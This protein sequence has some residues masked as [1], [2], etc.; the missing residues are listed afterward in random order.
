MI[1]TSDYLW[2]KLFNTKGLGIKSLH[3]IYDVL[4]QQQMSIVDLFKL[5]S[6]RF[7]SIFSSHNKGKYSSINYYNITS[8]DES[9][10]Y[11]NYQK[12]KE[13][14]FQIIS[15]EHKEYPKNV[16]EKMQDNAPPIL[17]CKGYIPLL[18]TLGI[19]IVGSRDVDECAVLL[20]K[21]IAGSLALKGYNVISGYAKGVDTNAHLGALEN[22]GTT[23]AILSYGINYLSIKKDF[24]Q[25]N[26]ERNTLFVTQF[27]PSEKFSGRNAMARNKLVCSMSKAVVVIASGPEIDSS[28]KMSGTYDAGKTALLMNIP[29]FVLS[30][31]LFEKAPQGN[32]DLIN[33]G[34]IEIK[35][36]ND[37]ISTFENNISNHSNTQLAESKNNSSSS[38]LN[39][40]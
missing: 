5:D 32:I 18:N 19:S 12:I 13:E 26:W 15:L 31:S 2:Y 37:I 6:E 23:T 39:F 36:G 30:P 20:T 8:N 25:L 34:G 9:K 35:N 14:G 16:K 17:F 38:Q 28:G 33:K 24:R 29:L 11:F 4:S 3:K 27:A 21:S 40:F 7:H 22:D 1:L 10:I